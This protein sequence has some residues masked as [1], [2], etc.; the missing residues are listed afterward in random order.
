VAAGFG[1]LEQGVQG[2]GN[3]FA[4]GAAKADDA[5]T[6]FFNPAGLTRLPGTQVQMAVHIIMPSTRFDNGGAT[7][8][9]AFGMGEQTSATLSGGNGGDAGEVGV[10]PNFYYAQQLT[11]RLHLGLGV[12]VPFGLSTKYK[13]GWVGRYHALESELQTININPSLAFKMHPGLSIGMGLNVQYIR[14]RLTN[15]I[16]QSGL[17]LGLAASRRI[18]GA[19]CAK[20]GLVTPGS[21]ATDAEAELDDATDISLGYNVGVLL[22]PLPS[23]RFG[24]HYRSH[25]RHELEG[26]ATFK[27]VNATFA[28]ATGL[29][30]KQDLNA[31]I[32]LPESVSFSVYHQF[33][34]QWAGM[35]DISWTRWSRFDQLVVKFDGG[36]PTLA[37]PQNWDDS[38]RYALGVSYT[39]DA[40]WTFRLGTAYDETPIPNAALRTPRIPGADRYWISAGVSYDYADTVG[41]DIG[42]A[43]LFVDDANINNTEVST[44]HVLTGTYRAD[45]NIF[46]AQLRYQF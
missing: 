30:V 17:C 11:E 22:T 39:P 21:T 36:Q 8:N 26:K 20:A 41:V 6:V 9:A 37:Q 25:I 4:G 5:S 32:T 18:P 19:L 15:A 45:A 43:H 42:Y 31:K 44:G 1:L 23:T 27:R 2:L 38:W 35:V 12:N 33:H 40:H 28:G 3:A 14:A 10:V 46:S 16:D 7:L 29:L 34:T 13:N 24:I